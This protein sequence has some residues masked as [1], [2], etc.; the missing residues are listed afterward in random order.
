MDSIVAVEEELMVQ[1]NRPFCFLLH[2]SS[3]TPLKPCVFVWN[4]RLLTHRTSAFSYTIFLTFSGRLVYLVDQFLA[5][6]LAGLHLLHALQRTLQ[7]AF[8]YAVGMGLEF[9]L[10]QQVLG[11]GRELLGKVEVLL[12]RREV[13]AE[14]V[15]GLVEHGVHEAWRLLDVVAWERLAEHG[16]VVAAGSLAGEGV[17]ADLR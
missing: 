13:H 6:D 12:A 4:C 2:R 1:R 15:E 5:A 17:G 9:P 16:T 3:P 7:S 8:T 11:D 10:S 14:L